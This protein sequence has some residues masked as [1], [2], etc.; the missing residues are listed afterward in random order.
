MSLD[1]QLEQEIKQLSQEVVKKREAGMRERA[2]V[3]Y[4]LKERVAP[5]RKILQPSDRAEEI[6]EPESPPSVLPAYTKDAPDEVKLQIE[7]LLE[8]AVHKGVNTALKKALKCPP[9][10]EDAFRDALVDHL[11]DLM[12]EK[13]YI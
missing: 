7:E 1:I 8:M 5:Q 10:I 4:V 13:K 6:T 11:L 3:E 12:K 2:A 9:Y